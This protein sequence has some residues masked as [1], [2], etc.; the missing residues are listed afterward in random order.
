MV[1]L[2]WSFSSGG[3]EGGREGGKEVG[4]EGGREG[5]RNGHATKASQSAF[6]CFLTHSAAGIVR[7]AWHIDHGL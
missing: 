2:C 1:V 3:K 7:V 4:R 5:E 6:T